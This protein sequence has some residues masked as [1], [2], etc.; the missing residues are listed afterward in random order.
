M[1]VV[2]SLWVGPGWVLGAACHLVRMGWGLAGVGRR[3]DWML[4]GLVVRWWGGIA[5]RLVA[6]RR[7][8]VGVSLDGLWGVSR[9]SWWLVVEVGWIGWLG[10]RFGLVGCWGWGD[11][12]RWGW[13]VG[14]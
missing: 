12:W 11:G 9:G 14:R 10:R 6:A 13:G 3:R 2:Q 1:G 8:G 7:A 4:R 5:H